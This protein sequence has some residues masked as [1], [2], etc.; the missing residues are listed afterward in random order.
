MPPRAPWESISGLGGLHNAMIAPL[1]KLPMAGALW[2]Q[3]ESNAGDATG[4]ER[5][6]EALIAGWRSR[7]GAALGFIVVQ[8]PNFGTPPIQ[9]GE[10]GWAR[11]RDAQRR[12]AVA[13][14]ATGL[15]VIID[16]GDDRDLHPPNKLLVGQ[17]A[18]NVA[19]ALVYGS[20]AIVDG[21]G[22][23]RAW[24]QGAR[25]LV[26]FVPPEETLVVA[27][28]ST[29]VAFELCG[30]DASS[31]VYADAERVDN[32][33]LLTAPDMPDPRRVRYCWADA[34]ICNL[35][36]SSGL[37]VGTFEIPISHTGRTSPSR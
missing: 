33:I 6:L 17:R 34:P 21:I 31:C 14:P 20:S 23:V 24:M 18:A 13:D 28:D 22:P 25:T 1:G 7:F 19:G 37:P 29:P 8:L 2:Y 9:P 27:G 26:E 36:G 5:L 16:A 12:A 35:Y 3:G 32:R 10:S 11:I 30:D 15:V 4:Y